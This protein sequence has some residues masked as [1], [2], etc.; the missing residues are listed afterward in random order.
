MRRINNSKNGCLGTF[1]MPSLLFGL[2][3]ASFVSIYISRLYFSMEHT[4]AVRQAL[5]RYSEETYSAPS[6]QTTNHN[7]NKGSIRIPTL[8][9]ESSSSVER[10]SETKFELIARI[11]PN[12]TQLENPPLQDGAT[13]FSACML[14][15]DDNHRLTEWMAYHYHVLPLRYMIVAVD[16]RSKTSPTH[17]LNQ[18]RRRGVHIIEWNDRDFWRADL[19]LVP[20]P[21]DAELQTKRDRHRGRQKYFYKQCLIRCKKDKRTWV[22]LHDSDEFLVYNHA[23]GDKFKEWEERRSKTSRMP[24][25]KPSQTP[26]TTA[27]AGAMIRYINHERDAGLKYYKSPCIGIPRTMFGADE[28]QVDQRAIVKQVPKDFHWAAP[29]MDTLKYR[30]HATRN[31]FVKNA[32]G[33]VIIDVSRIDVARTPYFMSLHRPIKKLCPTPWINDWSA[34]L[35]INHYLGSWHSYS[36]RDDSRRGNERSWEQWTYKAMTLGE[37]TDDNIRPWLSGLVETEGEDVAREMLTNVGLPPNYKN[38]DD[39]KWHL[40]PE[41]LHEILSTDVTIKQD[42]KAVAFED[43][44][45]QTYRSNPA[46]LEE[47]KIDYAKIQAEKGNANTINSDNEEIDL[48]EV[49]EDETSESEQSDDN[50]DEAKEIVESDEGGVEQENED[51]PNM[52]NDK[53]EIVNQGELDED[54]DDE[55]EKTKK[56]AEQDDVQDGLEEAPDGNHE[57][58]EQ[59]Q[60]EEIDDKENINVAENLVQEHDNKTINDDEEESEQVESNEINPETVLG[61]DEDSS[62][63]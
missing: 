4:D 13:T 16:P 56:D 53:N 1:L 31:D 52:D 26:P 12:E 51:N 46:M 11:F 20:I 6:K 32:L 45:R 3:F 63:E 17:I 18:W 7:N 27:E 41:R 42:N 62:K 37:N 59:G 40:I 23:G 15:M 55:N 43:W 9:D 29:L 48:A 10:R 54:K 33:K 21:D 39:H 36:F 34:G 30:Q 35:R 44:V 57:N 24:R 14:V 8:H 28:S 5:I 60:Q 19:K 61:Q 22:S 58:D 50:E 38:G 25:M 49:D 47:R 2:L